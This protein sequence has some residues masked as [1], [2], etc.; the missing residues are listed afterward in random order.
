MSNVKIKYF[1][2]VS[3]THTFEFLVTLFSFSSD[4]CLKQNNF[5]ELKKKANIPTQPIN[6][7]IKKYHKW[8]GKYIFLS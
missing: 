6:L 2:T 3:G 7:I 1:K 8:K 5:N 4:D